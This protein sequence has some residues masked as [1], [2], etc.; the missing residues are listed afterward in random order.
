M[1]KLKRFARKKNYALLLLTGAVF[2]FS[3]FLIPRIV[4]SQSTS[5]Q[6]SALP[7]S[8]QLTIEQAEAAKALT[9]A[10]Q[11]AV[12]QELRRTGGQLTPGA[13]D[14]I[15]ARPEFQG[16]SPEEISKGMELLQQQKD[17]RNEAEKAKGSEIKG[18]E[19]EKET[20]A[21]KTVI[22]DFPKGETLFVRAQTQ[23]KY[24]DISLDLKPFGHDFFRDSAVK[25]ITQR[26]DIPVPVNYVVGPGDEVKIVLW[27]RVNASYS[28]PVDRDGKVNIPNIGPLTVAGMTF[29]QMAGNLIKQ[30]EQMTGTSVDISMG[31]L[32][33]IPVFIL[34]E[35]RRPGAYTIGSLSTITDALL[36][37]GGPSEIGTMRN[38]QLKRNNKT[39]QTFDLYDLLLKGDKSRDVILSEGDIVFVPII[40]PYVGI[41]GNIKRPAIYELKDDFTLK[42][43]FDLSGGIIPTA[44]TQ[45][46]QV[47]RTVKNEKKIVVDINDKN[48]NKAKNIY[49]QDADIVKVFSIVD[50]NVNVV[51]LNGNVK[52]GGKYA[53]R[54]GMRLSDILKDENELLP[55][56]HFDYALIKRL[57]PPV[58]DTVLI[59]FNLG[60][61]LLRSDFSSNFEL[62]PQDQ[63]YIFSRSFFKD[64]PFFTVSGE[65]RKAGKFELLQNLRV[66]DAVLAAGNITKDAYLKKG[67]IIRVNRQKEYSTIYFE[68]ARAMND[69]PEENVLLQ[70][71]DHVIIHSVWEKI[72]KKR[73]TIEGEVLNPGSY[74]LTEQMTINDIVFK[75][76]NVLESAYLDDVEIVSRR[77]DSENRVSL[78]RK[79][80][81]LKKS[82]AGETEH[83]LVL[84]PH[85]HII[86]RKIPDWGRVEF[87]TLTGEF[88]F[89][90]RY[91]IKKG[92]TL[93]SVLERAGGFS[94]NAYLRG[95]VFTR[96]SVR[97]M[98]QKV[99]FE[100]ADRLE[101]ELLSASANIG[102]AASK[103]EIEAKKADLLQKQ[104]FVESLR[105]LKATGRMTVHLSRVEHLKGK[106]YDIELNDGDT[107]FV[108]TKNNIINVM[109]AVMAQGTHVYTEK[110]KYQDFINESGG[111]A[112]SADKPNVFILKVDGSARKLDRGGLMNWDFSWVSWDP[113]NPEVRIK[114]I[115]PGDTIVVPVKTEHIAWLR[116]FKDI[117]QILMNTAVTAGIV[118]K[119]F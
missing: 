111:Y 109:G 99:I 42:N 50:K 7:I 107:I 56:T 11:E 38:V 64:N 57:K 91:I 96:G 66:K 36:L 65:V 49:L 63:I 14:A 70:E 115:E 84:F 79:N 87:V 35:V 76:G 112:D 40:G 89:P 104:K 78:T 1:V 10:H 30:A 18:A 12:M 19:R 114:E 17:A 88:L 101:K 3:L 25:V 95:A 46:M 43:L 6:T 61:L 48:L 68:V 83:N 13:I 24:Q 62:Q 72:P 58:M 20:L 59:P 55:D 75:A 90:G 15:R 8:P 119:L 32:R 74:Q 93:S 92:E 94:A 67:Q 116:E 51:Y 9:P 29:E 27:G 16:L 5:V 117:T 110:K 34:G 21:T 26:S 53:L 97:E 37:A 41:A 100:M 77:T 73:V 54:P 81:N 28:I 44:Y 106:E 52:R 103:E 80:I 82:L 98:Q 39:I 31:A 71:D 108:P 86:I 22:G 45:Q 47:E 4:L 102:T 2:I 85:D 118:L 60:D 23:G 113:S 69:D 105:Q 33:T